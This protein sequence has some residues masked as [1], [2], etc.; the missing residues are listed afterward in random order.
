MKTKMKK[1]NFFVALSLV[2]ALSFAQ[3][4]TEKKSSPLEISGSADLYYKYDFSKKSNIGTSFASDQN[5][6][7]L[8]MIDI[9]LKK[10]SGKASFVGEVSL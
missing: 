4:A 3:E 9:A 7:S 2:S 1:L 5:S 6:L 10:T 8:G